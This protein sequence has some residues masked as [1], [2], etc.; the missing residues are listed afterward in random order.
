M[1]VQAALD[2]LDRGTVIFESG[3]GASVQCKKHKSW[4]GVSYDNVR[5]HD[6][7]TIL[8]YLIEAFDR[9]PGCIEEK[10]W[11]ATRFPENAEL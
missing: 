11:A 8:D 4:V 7:K 2:R 1:A 3:G 10:Q 5:L 6:E 9:C